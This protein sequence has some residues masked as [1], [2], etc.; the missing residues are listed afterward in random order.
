MKKSILLLA[1]SSLLLFGC[2]NTPSSSSQPLEDD[3]IVE[4]ETE[5]VNHLSSSGV[6]IDIAINRW[7]CIGIEYKGNFSFSDQTNQNAR[8]TN[9]NP[10]N[11]EIT[12]SETNTLTF[13]P[14]KEGDT[15]LCIYSE[16]GILKYRHVVK[17]RKKIEENQLTDFLINKV[18]HFQAYGLNGQASI[19]FLSEENAV[20]SGYDSS[21]YLGRIPFTY[22]FDGQSE[23]SSDEYKFTIIEFKNE[24]NDLQCV[25]FYLDFTGCIL[26]LM[27]ANI[28]VDVFTPVL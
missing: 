1:L 24:I 7:L 3:Q 10:E 6:L 27:T 17:A 20:F 16:E 21:T 12:L 2:D 13:T 26:H 18:D 4:L 8:I 19:T 23:N 22:R 14:K 28:T 11:I 15:I 5:E 25:S 9:S